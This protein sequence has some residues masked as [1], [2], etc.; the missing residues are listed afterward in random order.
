LVRNIKPNTNK[1]RFKTHKLGT[2]IIYIEEIQFAS[3]DLSL[4]LSLS[5][6][7]FS[8]FRSHSLILYFISCSHSLCCRNRKEKKRKGKA[9][10]EGKQGKKRR[11]KRINLLSKLIAY[12]V[13]GFVMNAGNLNAH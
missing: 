3:T 1:P 13:Y 9:E 4:S 8:L 11:G 7:A 12:H 6:L 2:N 10:R 5:Q